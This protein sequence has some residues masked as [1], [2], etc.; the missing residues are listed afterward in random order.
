MEGRS[1]I[2]KLADPALLETIDK[3][4]A[5]NIGEYVALP[6]LL[7]VGDQ[8]SGKSSV[9]EGLTGLP[10]PRDNQLCT[11]FATQIT[12]RRAPVT[13]ATVSVIPA[14]DAEPYH[15][16]K[17]RNWKKSDLSSFD[18]AKF[19]EIMKE[20]NQLM[21]LEGFEDGA[22]KKTF[23]IDVLKIEISGPEQEHLSVIDVPGI[24]RKTSLG[25]TTKNDIAMVRSM[26]TGYM[27]NPRS[28][29][30]AVIPA[31]VDIGTQEILDIA[32]QFDPEGQRTLGVLTK[33]DLVDKG[34][35]QEI[36]NIIE[37][38]THK[39]SL[40]WCIVRNSGQQELKESASERDEREKLFFA[41]QDP[42]NTIAKD[43]V[44]IVPLQNRLVEILGDLIRREFPNAFSSVHSPLKMTLLTGTIQVKSDINRRLKHCRH[45]LEALGPSRENSEQQ[46]KYLLALATRFQEIASFAL[47]AYYGGDDIFDSDTSL[48]LATAVVNRN[49]IF[50][51]D[52]H[53]KGHTMR[54]REDRSVNE[55]D[56]DDND[57]DVSD[58]GTDDENDEDEDNSEETSKTIVRYQAD[59]DSLEDILPEDLRITMP[60]SSGIRKWLEEVYKSSRGFEFGT[61]DAS[62]LPMIW[63]KQS[64]NWDA[65][66]LGY[67]SDIVLLVHAFSIT[68]LDRIC[69]DDKVRKGLWSVLQDSLY[70]KYRKGIDHTKWLLRIER[71][72]TPLTTNHYFANNLEKSR[73]QRMKD[74]LEKQQA[75]DPK[76]GNY[77]KIENMVGMKQVSSNLEHTV[78]D[79]HDILQSYYK[80]AYKRFVDNVCMQAADFHLVTG[81]DAPVRV[82]C[83]TFVSELTIEQLEF[84]AGESK[85]TK[86]RR[87]ELAHEIESL[88]NGRKLL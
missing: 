73:E 48:R 42:W 62:L 16:D 55:E 84:I 35:E 7:V 86:R 5:L 79:L 20:V 1:H 66:A 31:N 58:D 6:Q 49:S 65:L 85:V 13:K 83:P 76:I 4:F 26:V 29:M 23:T 57:D 74:S 34:A 56:D 18:G 50:S 71:S 43:R 25:V 61:F 9:L 40:G 27:R 52:V 24:F 82:F 11:R 72:G 53:E 37:G 12:F 39:L 38:K 41:T 87:T 68:L 8:S 47:R 15:A 54:F 67:I 21:G 3:L 46:S 45:Q 33:P 69:P 30:L 60:K 59:L 10:Y 44:G 64:A 14:V 22:A 51:D 19:A 63:K 2:D 81:P 70:D 36:V 32:E 80:V 77:V 88:E 28:A 78:S 17:L 75:Y